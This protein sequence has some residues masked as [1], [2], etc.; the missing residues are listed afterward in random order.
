MEQFWDELRL[1]SNVWGED[2]GFALQPLVNTTC[3]QQLLGI[4]PQKIKR[5]A[6][7]TRE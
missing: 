2:R 3:L 7:N 5:V 4:T 6:L 1:S